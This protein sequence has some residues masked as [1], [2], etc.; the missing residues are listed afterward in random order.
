MQELALTYD[1]FNVVA[2]SDDPSD[3]VWVEAFLRPAFDLAPGENGVC[4]TLK[5]NADFLEYARRM[6]SYAEARMAAFIL[7]SGVEDLPC[8]K[9]SDGGLTAYDP[10]FDAAYSIAQ[11]ITVSDATGRAHGRRAR[12]A[13]MRAIRE[14]VM[15]HLWCKRASLL[16]AAAFVVEDQAV[17]VAGD[18]GAGKTSLLCAAILGNPRA[19]LLSNDRLVLSQAGGVLCARALPSIVS[20]RSGSLEVVPSLAERLGGLKESYLGSL[21][22]TESGP[23]RRLISPGQLASALGSSLRRDAPVSCCVFPRIDPAQRSFRIREL[24]GKELLTRTLQCAF[25]KTSLGQRSELFGAGNAPPF[26]DAKELRHRLQ[27]AMAG[28]RC[29]EL[30]MGPGLYAP[31]QIQRLI[32]TLIT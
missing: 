11:D 3:L 29:Y 5:N 7:D 17:V 18:K 2:R 28:T 10:T 22:P 16:H 21:A 25:A 6:D 31:D 8:Y 14:R 4:F 24:S 23:A 30:T 15:D 19:A 1:G 13:L 26:P 12:G 32:S 20:I 9:E 27:E